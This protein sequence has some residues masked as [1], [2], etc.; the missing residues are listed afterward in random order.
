MCGINGFVTVEPMRADDLRTAAHA[1]SARQLHRGPDDKGEWV[2][3]E[4]GVALGFRR[5]A[6]LDLSVAGHQPMTS[7]DGRFVAVFNGEIYNYI[8]IRDELDA[9]ARHVW[10]GHSDTEVILEA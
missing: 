6:I 2:D 9:D 8:A 4:T 7:H 5:L 1:M 3:A 10:R